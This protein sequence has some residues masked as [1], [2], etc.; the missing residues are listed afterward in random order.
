MSE[1]FIFGLLSTAAGRLERVRAMKLGLTHDF[2]PIDTAADQPY[3]VKVR[4]GSGLTIEGLT[5]FYTIDGR[6]PGKSSSLSVAMKRTTIE[7]DTLTWSYLEE[8]TGE[9]PG[10][11]Q[12]THVQYVIEGIT[13][14]GRKI[15]CPY[16]DLTV[17]E[18]MSES[19]DQSFV[20]RLSRKNSSGVFGFYVNEHTTAKWLEESVIYQVFV[21]RFAPDPDKAF[22]N[23]IDRSGIYGGTI[24]GLIS[25]LDYLKDLGIS[26]L[27]LTP[28]FP[29]PSHHGYDPKA[30]NTIEPRLG[31]EADW[32]ELVCQCQKRD[33]RIILDFVANH[34]SCEH[35][36]FESAQ[37]NQDS[38]TYDWFHFRQ[39]PD[40]YDCFFD[41]PEQPEVDSDNP[42]VRN[43]LIDSACYWLKKGCSGFRLD[44]AHGVTHAFWSA[45]SNTTRTI[46]PESITI[47]EITS[48]PD[49]VRSY[50]NRMD[51]CLDFKLLEFLR[52]FF[53]LN[54]LSVS[55]F[56]KGLDQHF[57]YFADHLL[58]PS[59]L[60][61]HDMNRF[62]W[63]VNGDRRRLKLAALCQF[64]LPSP[65]I[66]Y[67]GTEVGLSQLVSLGRLEES[68]LPMLWN[69]NK[70]DKEI[71]SFY[72]E[73]IA[74]RRQN[75]R[76]WKTRQSLILDD[77]KGI[78]G[79]QCGNLYVILNNSS[80]NH[81]LTLA[82][83]SDHEH[84]MMLK[85]EAENSWHSSFNSLNLMAYSGVVMRRKIFIE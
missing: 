66:I 34:I 19:F 15:S 13:N 61:N 46:N 49:L 20:E 65:P 23:P 80:E 31:S 4:A 38:L 56:S 44:Y 16:I 50:A 63:I 7:W 6:A 24:K 1:E 32:D 26:C 33:L 22:L 68:R 67:Y 36:A 11:S 25:K 81:Q 10:Q 37:N 71:L 27:W 55:Q 42:Q 57:A 5:L 83:F 75:N 52:G 70:Q 73:L 9:I 3:V 12:G 72:K 28:I 8:W 64:T 2:Y 47:G 85:S 53:V 35:P 43:Y 48:S 39:W 69:E 54:T 62:L 17:I 40:S 84:E 45:F 59:F 76:L 41:V 79:Y 60:D 51:G 21:D 30:H 74:L 77:H 58:L 78:Y 82:N 18:S 14:T 29:S